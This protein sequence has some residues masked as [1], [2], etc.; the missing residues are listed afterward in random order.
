M[1]IFAFYRAIVALY[2]TSWLLA[3]IVVD[4][5]Q[6]LFGVRWLVFVTHWAYA[7]LCLYFLWAAIITLLC[8]KHSDYV[9]ASDEPSYMPWYMRAQWVLF[10]IAIPAAI[11]VTIGY[12]TVIFK[13]SDPNFVVDSISISLHAVNCL[14]A[15]I[16]LFFSATPV[17]ILHMVYPMFF[18]VVYVIVTVIYWAAGGKDP[19]SGGNFVYKVLDYGNEPGTAVGVALGMVLV[20][21]PVMH[22]IVWALYKLRERLCGAEFP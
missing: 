9:R 17:R 7:I 19:Y 2:A 22:V 8:Q 12:W 14:M 20:V 10:D 1:F 15:V 16:E 6:G 11:T 5:V 13:P 3:S 18:G 21:L 4:G